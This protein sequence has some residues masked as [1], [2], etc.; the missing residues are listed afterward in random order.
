MMDDKSMMD[1]DGYVILMIFFSRELNLST[2]LSLIFS[3]F[4]S[5][6]YYQPFRNCPGTLG[7]K[8]RE[9]EKLAV[10]KNT[11][12][13][14]MSSKRH[15]KET[16]RQLIE[17]INQRGNN[18]KC[19]ECHSTHP[20]WASY[21]LGIFL[22]GR[23]ALAHR[24]VLGPPENISKVK[25]LTLD[26]WL[27]D[28]INNLRRIGNKK[29]KNKWNPKR[30]PF[31]YDADDNPDAVDAYLRDKYILGKFRDEPIES[32]DYDDRRSGYSDDDIK[33]RR[34]RLNSY[35]SPISGRSR[36]N[37]S[38]RMRSNSTLVPRLT[39]R[40]LTTFENTLYQP[41]VAKILGFG[42]P[43]RDAVLESLL[44]SEGSI[45][46]A[47]DILDAKV[48]QG[49]EERPPELPR[50]PATA[51][52]STATGPASSDWWSKT[53]SSVSQVSAAPQ[54]TGAPTG[55]PQITGAATQPQIYQY[56]DPVTGQVSYVDANGQQYL[57]PSNPQH[58]Q[59]LMLQVN[60]QLIAQQTNKQNILSLYNQPTGQQQQQQQQPQQQMA[61]QQMAQQQMAQQQMAQQQMAQQQMAQQ[62]QQQQLAQQPTAFGFGTQVPQYTQQ[63]GF[64]AQPQTQQF[65]GF[66]GQ[67]WR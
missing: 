65:T 46:M 18:N 40:K 63:T 27:S 13:T 64:M 32:S 59:Q 60:P 14:V 15:Q 43:D 38:A 16:E 56:T 26:T 58:Q 36:A 4:L 37:S 35:A 17:I 10:P 28:R 49:N 25:S 30:V 5:S 50:R 67:N 34:S 44:L 23:C 61:Q 8:A 66:Q 7:R 45:E 1:N 47:L 6:V 11:N 42:Y 33:S 21:N 29:A 57:D 22:C 41:Q 31:P 48:N 39:H 3:Y 24:R 20:T 54:V 52:S 9:G 51:A 19:G 2:L 12:S 55:A 62:Y 53:D